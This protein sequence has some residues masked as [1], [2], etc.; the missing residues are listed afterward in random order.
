M[1][2]IIDRIIDKIA[3]CECM[4]TSAKVKIATKNLPQAAKEGDIIRKIDDTYII[5]SAASKQRL[6]DM[7]NRMNALFA[8]RK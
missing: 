4:K 8:R 2:L 1:T 5:D 7:T 6:T 3:I